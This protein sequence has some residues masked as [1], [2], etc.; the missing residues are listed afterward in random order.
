MSPLGFKPTTPKLKI[1]F[2]QVRLNL[3]YLKLKIFFSERVEE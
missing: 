2:Q 3:I 1:N